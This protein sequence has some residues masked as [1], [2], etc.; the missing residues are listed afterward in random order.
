MSG[1]PFLG[2]LGGYLPSPSECPVWLSQTDKWGADHAPLQLKKRLLEENRRPR[3]SAREMI[4]FKVEPEPRGAFNSPLIRRQSELSDWGNSIVADWEGVDLGCV[5]DRACLH[6]PHSWNTDEEILY[7]C[8]S[9][10]QLFDI[11]V[12]SF[13]VCSQFWQIDATFREKHSLAI[14]FSFFRQ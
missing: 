2:R 7:S 13:S 10:K 8:A 14:F 1:S 3:V 6:G 12:L 5:D 9:K 4:M 11:S